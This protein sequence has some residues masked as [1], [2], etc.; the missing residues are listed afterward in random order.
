MLYC[1][2]DEAWGS[3]NISPLIKKKKY[4]KKIIENF[5]ETVKETNE[6]S[7]IN[8]KKIINH[9]MKCK[10]CYKKLQ[11]KFRPKIL[12]LL[13]D[14]IDEYREMIVLVL[15]GLFLMLFFNLINNL[16]NNKKN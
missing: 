7:D 14:I 4:K 1:S 12:G 15:I 8:C 5:T 13:H 16:L 3:N 6:L 9:V 2:I 11:H 10:K